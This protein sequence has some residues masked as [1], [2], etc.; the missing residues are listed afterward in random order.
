MRMSPTMPVGGKITGF[1]TQY[2]IPTRQD[3]G[4]VNIKFETT[5]SLQPIRSESIGEIVIN[6]PAPALAGKLDLSRNRC[7]AQ[8]HCI[9]PDL[10]GN[11]RP[12]WRE[13][14]PKSEMIHMGVHGGWNRPP[15]LEVTSCFMSS[16]KNL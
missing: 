8:K 12:N 7:V 14:E 16:I 4:R 6:T 3:V 11:G 10:Y 5:M 2:K 1:P 13:K 9:L 15:V